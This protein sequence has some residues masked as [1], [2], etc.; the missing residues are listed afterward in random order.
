[1]DT[2]NIPLKNLLREAEQLL[3]KANRNVGRAWRVIE[4]AKLQ[5][6]RTSTK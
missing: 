1:M 4:D 3:R 5:L 2:K 6:K